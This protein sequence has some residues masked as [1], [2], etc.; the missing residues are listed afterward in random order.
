MKTLKMVHIKKKMHWNPTD[1]ENPQI[2]ICLSCKATWGFPITWLPYGLLSF[3]QLFVLKS[4]CLFSSFYMTS[5]QVKGWAPFWGVKQLAFHN[6]YEIPSGRLGTPM[7]QAHAVLVGLFLCV[8]AAEA[9]DCIPERKRTVYPL[10]NPVWNMS[11]KT[12]K[13]QTETTIKQ[14]QIIA[15][16]EWRDLKHFLIWPSSQEETVP[17]LPPRP[18]CWSSSFWRGHFTSL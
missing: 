7:W 8:G 9:G 13:Q 2:T 14:N 11:L 12:N 3:N 10:F 17:S 15:A 18:S 16:S 1:S 4:D 6:S 5:A